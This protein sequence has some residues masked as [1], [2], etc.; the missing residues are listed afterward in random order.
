M[1][2]NFLRQ[3]DLS[4]K[5]HQLIQ[6]D[7]DSILQL[8]RA[9]HGADPEVWLADPEGYEKNG[10]VQ[11]DSTA[12][13]LLAYSR[14]ERTI[15]AT[16]GCNSCTHRLGEALESLPGQRLQEIAGSS[17]VRL[18]MLL[19]LRQLAAESLRG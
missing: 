19:R 1:R 17:D 10:R 13:R 7:I 11:R 5:A 6:F 9:Q 2:L 3:A 4:E 8:V 16:D 18:E 14:A 12:S 15:Y